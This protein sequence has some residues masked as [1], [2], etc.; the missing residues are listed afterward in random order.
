MTRACDFTVGW[1][2]GVTLVFAPLAFGAVHFWASAAL[3]A[4]MCAAAA[5]WCVRTLFAAAFPAA[6]RSA[7]VS[8]PGPAS[9][10]RPIYA[11]AALALAAWLLAGVAPLPPSVLRALSP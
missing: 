7:P 5:G 9:R 1:L 4:L 8:R 2:L 3:E 11:L 10:Q 6:S